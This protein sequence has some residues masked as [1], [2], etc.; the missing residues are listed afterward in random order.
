[1]ETALGLPYKH[2]SRERLGGTN[3]T[4]TRSRRRKIYKKRLWAY[5]TNNKP[6][7]R[8]LRTAE[9]PNNDQVQ[10]K[11]KYEYPDMHILCGVRTAVMDEC[12]VFYRPQRVKYSRL[13]T[14]EYIMVRIMVLVKTNG[15]EG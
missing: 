11:Y 9:T 8:S 4:D 12:E 3:H 6:Q 10:F 15:T 1:M 13:C 7:S 14:Q 2:L 5:R